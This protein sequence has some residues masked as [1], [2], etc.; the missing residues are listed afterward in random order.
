MDNIKK[1]QSTI[2]ILCFKIEFVLTSKLF[3]ESKL[4]GQTIRCDDW[5]IRCN[6]RTI[7]C[8][9]RASQ[10]HVMPIR[11]DNWACSFCAYCRKYRQCD[12]KQYS[13]YCKLCFHINNP[14]LCYT[15]ILHKLDI[16]VNISSNNYFKI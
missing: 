14:F 10:L 4:L 11:C 6:D 2:M 1:K 3:A 16:F 5:S 9:N 7:G 15:I 12:K 13:K 8:N